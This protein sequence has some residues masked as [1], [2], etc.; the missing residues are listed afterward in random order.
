MM[1]S[2]SYHLAALAGAFVAAACSSDSVS[3]TLGETKLATSTSNGSGGSDT[4]TAGPR[5]GQTWTLETIN[6]L[7]LGVDKAIWAPSTG[8]DTLV[9]NTTPVANATVEVRPY[10]FTPPPAGGGDSST[11]FK[12]LGVEATLTTDANGKFTYKVKNPVV[13]VAGQPSP[14]RGYFVTI[15]PPTGSPYKPR[16]RASVIFA[17]PFPAGTW[18]K[19]FLDRP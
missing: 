1:K 8:G 9:A 4:T 2:R 7:V 3:P 14:K 6:G 13:V 18:M 17:E 10:E 19:F 11:V 16:E 12:D 15:T 5:D